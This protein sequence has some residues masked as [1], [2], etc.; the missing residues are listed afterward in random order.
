L[1]RWTPLLWLV[2]SLCLT[3]IVARW[4]SQRVANLAMLLTG[5]Q[6][7]TLYIHFLVFLPGTLLHELSHWFVAQVLGVRT[8]RLELGPK[9]VRGGVVQMG[10]VTYQRSDVVRESL[11]GL[12][13]LITGSIVVVLLTYRRFGL[14][15][16]SVLGFQ[17][18]WELV[19]RI[20]QAPDSWIW[21]YLLLSV[22]NTMLPSSSDRRSWGMLALYVLLI[23]GLLYFAGALTAVSP[24]VVAWLLQRA[25]DLAFAFGLTVL[26]DL[27]LGSTLWAVSALA[28]KLLGRRVL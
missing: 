20:W 16:P 21:L 10:A 25:Q 12:A 15:V 9:V 27:I 8:G 6:S 1:D 19:R 18:I 28:G 11:V 22:S 13:P 4:F 2:I 3:V 24:T 14:V 5:S 7:A 26:I 17:G 23:V